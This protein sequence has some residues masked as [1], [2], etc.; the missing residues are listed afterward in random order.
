MRATVGAMST[1]AVGSGSEK[2]DLNCGPLA[3]SVRFVSGT[4]LD[5]FATTEVA[6]L[7]PEPPPMPVGAQE[8]AAAGPK[9]GA[10]AGKVMQGEYPQP[11]RPVELW[12]IGADERITIWNPAVWRRASRMLCAANELSVTISNRFMCPPPPWASLWIQGCPLNVRGGR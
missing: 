10:I 12:A 2:L 11:G 1:F 9:E 8:K 5:E 4:G 6:I 3:I 7:E